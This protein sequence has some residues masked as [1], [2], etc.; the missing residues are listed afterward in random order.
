MAKS[1]SKLQRLYPEAKKEPGLRGYWPTG[2]WLLPRY[3]RLGE[4]GFYPG[5]LAKVRNGRSSSSKFASPPAETRAC[6]QALI[7]AAPS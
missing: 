3:S 5:L 7:Y 1:L 4:G 2:Y 6:R